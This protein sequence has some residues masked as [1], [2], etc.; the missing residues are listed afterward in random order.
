MVPY[1]KEIIAHG[2]NVE[3]LQARATAKATTSI[4]NIHSNH[5]NHH[6]AH[7][8]TVASAISAVFITNV[9]VAAIFI[10]HVVVARY[11]VL[12]K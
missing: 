7:I 11:N 2:K 5:H 9:V 3:P 4:K 1:N 6:K 10:T 8:C 12:I